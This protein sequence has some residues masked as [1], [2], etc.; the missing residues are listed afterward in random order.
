MA[1]VSEKMR[2]N[3]K[4]AVSVLASALYLSSIAHALHMMHSLR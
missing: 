2:S 1:D 4:V 3:R